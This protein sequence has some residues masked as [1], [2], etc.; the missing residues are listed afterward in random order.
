MIVKFKLFEDRNTI[1]VNKS[2]KITQNRIDNLLD[3]IISE[4]RL[5]RQEDIDYY[6]NK[7]QDMV[8]KLYSK[9]KDGVIIGIENFP[10][11]IELYRIIDEKLE[12]IKQ[13]ELGRYWCYDKNWIKNEEFH[14]SVGF[15]KN[16][17]WFIVTATF[18]KTDI[19]VD[20][21]LEMLIVNTGEREIRIKD[22]NTKPI[23]YKIE[24]YDN[25]I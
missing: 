19:D 18:K 10:K 3:Y 4:W 7:I 6:K 12:N 17:D 15:D 8:T 21:T 23:K 24:K 14:D 13:D 1:I 5:N 2:F 11:E 22:K 16:K 20:G 9:D 25:K